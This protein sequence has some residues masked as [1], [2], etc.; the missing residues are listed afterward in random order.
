MYGGYARPFSPFAVLPGKPCAARL[1]GNVTRTFTGSLTCQPQVMWRYIGNDSRK[2][3]ADG[4]AMRGCARSDGGV[5]AAQ[6]SRYGF[7]TLC[8]ETGT[9]Q[10]CGASCRFPRG[11]ARTPPGA[12]PAGRGTPHDASNAPRHP[13]DAM[14]RS[15]RQSFRRIPG[16]RTSCRSCS[17]CWSCRH[18]KA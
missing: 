3:L 16:G 6:S 7:A 5:F 1:C 12:E 18:S 9:L 13:R 14:A 17:S 10:P 2:G 15:L 4:L 8:A 11:G